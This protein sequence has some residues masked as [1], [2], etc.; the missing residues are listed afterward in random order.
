MKGLAEKG[1]LP[2]SK[3]THSNSKRK[4]RVQKNETPDLSTL[5]Q[6]MKKKRHLLYSC[7]VGD[8]GGEMGILLRKD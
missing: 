3:G 6:D 2:A 4:D 1:K 5:C 7:G 8:G